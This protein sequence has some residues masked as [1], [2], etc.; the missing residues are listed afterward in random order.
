M[1]AGWLEATA[2]GELEVP[3]DSNQK[4]MWETSDSLNIQD[5]SP[6]FQFLMHLFCT[7]A[8]TCSILDWSFHS[9]MLMVVYLSLTAA[10]ES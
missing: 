9:C 8:C 2:D 5:F 3:A 1:R 10:F 7:G 6:L 4:F